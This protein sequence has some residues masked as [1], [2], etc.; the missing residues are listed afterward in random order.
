MNST[1]WST[2]RIGSTLERIRKGDNDINMSCF[3]ER[4]VELRARK[5]I[6]QLTPEEN[7]EFEKCSTDIVHFVESHCK[8]MTDYGRIL[9][10]LRDFQEEILSTLGEEI[11]DEELDDFSPAVRNYIL[12]SSR[13]TGKTTTVSAFFAWY[14]CFHTDRNM[15][16]V[17]NKEKT[18]IEIVSKVV[19]IF[20][21]L[22]F[23]LKP[24]IINIGATGL[25][26]DNGC[27]LTSQATT[28][29]AAIGFTIHVLYLD[30][31]AH[32]NDKLGREF[33]RSVYP[34]LS[35]SKISQCI[36][37]ST[38]NGMDN[39]F[40][41]IWDKAN[42]G[43]NSFRFKRVDYW[44]VPEHDEK[45]A[46]Q[47]RKDFGEEEF[48]QEFELSFDR[49][50]NLLLTSSQLRW[51]K[52]I[53]KKFVYTK[54]L[55]HSD[56]DE[57]YYEGKLRWDPCF[58]PNGEFSDS[59]DRFVLCNDIAEGKDEGE[60][61]DN[62]Y[63]VTNIYKVELK[64]LAKL[65]KLKKEQRKISNLFRFR[66]VGAFQD[67]EGDEEVMANVNKAIVFDQ[68][69]EE[70]CK[71]V[72][73]MNFN[74]KAFTK[75]F[76]NHNNYFEDLFMRSHHTAPNP[77]EEHKRRKKIGFK[78]TRDKDFFCK[79]ARKLIEERTIIPVDSKAG[80]EFRSFGR[81]KGS[82]KGVAKHDD[83]AMSTINLSRFYIE[84]EYSDWLYDFLDSLPDSP[85]KR[86]A[87]AVLEEPFE[88]TDLSDSE[89]S[90]YMDSDERKDPLQDIFRQEEKNRLKHNIPGQYR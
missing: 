5:L 4:D 25:Y 56:L 87:Y 29:T 64:S 62:D 61:K 58:D 76:A 86:Y 37:T 43:D 70:R 73:E 24:G 72:T 10:E 83:L 31:F 18:T 13:Q 17:A 19:H 82:W 68:L 7:E 89:F 28:G 88:E 69:G 42:K 41:E 50:S 55:Q 77:D 33:W 12:M 2:E 47:M 63:N 79:L 45:W 27:M 90:L 23:Y 59:L 81:V 22:P 57:S 6:F 35:S 80:T 67:N 26:L 60:T 51:I 16:I 54:R 71:L 52:R 78:T 39:L 40:F 75:E 53:E 1:I 8:F 49:K 74:G 11:W 9:V 65:R 38:P 15:L 84:P 30:E 48:A 66:Q 46:E 14:L 85:E 36:I 34:T 44:E 3:H 20:R 32:I 21:G